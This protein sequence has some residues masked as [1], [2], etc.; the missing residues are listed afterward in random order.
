M[1]PVY[2]NNICQF[3]NIL[4]KSLKACHFCEI[5]DDFLKTC[6]CGRTVKNILSEGKGGG[7]GQKSWNINTE[8]ACR[9]NI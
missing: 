6:N 1:I 9:N 4:K 7:V 3:N 5:A 2:N 8:S